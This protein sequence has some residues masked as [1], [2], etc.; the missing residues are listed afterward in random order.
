METQSTYLL[1]Q[2]EIG[3]TK[4]KQT[5]MMVT[6]ATIFSQIPLSSLQEMIYNMLKTI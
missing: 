4:E 2:T 3:Q 6:K 5:T 1:S